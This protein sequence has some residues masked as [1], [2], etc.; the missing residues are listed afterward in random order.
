MQILLAILMYALWTSI[1][2]IGK[3]ALEHSPPI[4]LTSARMLLAALVLLVFLGIRKQLKIS[5]KQIIPLV[6][7]GVLSMYL[8]NICEFWSLKTIPSSKVCFIYGLSPFFAALFSYIHFKEKMT[9]LKWL[10]M[11]I[12]MVAMLP[13]MLEQSSAEQALALSGFL[14]LPVLSM[15][16]AVLFSVYGWVLLRVV[17]KNETISPMLA[18]GAAMLVGGILA[19]VHSFFVDSW[20]PVPVDAG[21]FGKFL[22]L[23]ALMTVISNIICYNL[24]GYMLKRFTATFLSFLGLVSPF[25]AS[26]TGYFVLHEPISWRILTSTAILS[27]GLFLVYQSELRQGYITSSEPAKA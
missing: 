12:G 4:F 10:G 3:I 19:L 27:I 1:F 7:L 9:P 14:T 11:G 15:F 5:K 23:I 25:F 8:T 20:T 17:V 2:S 16:A 22:G 24:Y 18:N 21:H 13:V 6:A 26:V